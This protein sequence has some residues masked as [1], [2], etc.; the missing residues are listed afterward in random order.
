LDSQS[1]PIAGADLAAFSAFLDGLDHHLGGRGGRKLVIAIDE[2]ENI[3][4]KIAVGVFP[5]DLLA[6]LRESMRCHRHLVWLFAGARSSIELPGARWTSY[7]VSTRSLEM[8]L[9]ELA[10]TRQLLTEPL[11]FSSL[12]ASGARR[13][14]FDLAFWGGEAGI[15]RLHRE[16]AGWP[17]LVQLLAEYAVQLVNQEGT[18]TIDDGLFERFCAK[19]IREGEN[20]FAELLEK[21]SRPE[22]WLYLQ[23]FRRRESMEWPADPRVESSLRR[24]WLIEPAPDGNCRLRVPLMGR[25]LKERT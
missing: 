20:V 6:V 24:R 21:E 2:Y 11:R 14:Q 8:P 5:E 23:Q 3:D 18:N 25:W 7:F 15:S 22:E 19:A 17:H 9:F 13:P 10:E 4:A 16:A 1:L 12:F